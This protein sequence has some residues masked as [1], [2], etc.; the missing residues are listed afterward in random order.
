MYP[1]RQHRP[2]GL[3]IIGSIWV[4]AIILGLIHG[5]HSWAEP[6]LIANET[7]YYCSEAWTSDQTYHFTITVFLV[8]FAVPLILLSFTYG[9]IVFKIFRH[10]TPG[11]ADL[12]R[13]RAQHSSKVK[14]FWCKGINRQLTNGSLFQIIKML[15]T[16]VMLFLFCWLPW[17]TLRKCT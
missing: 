9:S 15:S 6:I 12:A 5:T 8:T 14:V 7:N 17:H 3:L 11:N 4:A 2:F 10:S 16:I 1:L 13:D